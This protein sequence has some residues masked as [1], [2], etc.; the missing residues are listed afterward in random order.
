MRNL[1]RMFRREAWYQQGDVLIKPVGSV[2]QA[3]SPVAG[4]VLAEGEATGHK[5]AAV[6]ED[7]R[8]FILDG[9]L[10]MHA[11]TGTRVVHEEHHE[12]EIPPG[13]YV[14]DK[15]REYDHFAEEARPVLD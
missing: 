14:I 9:T 11:P 3:A 8:L 15:V 13:T 4:R 5:H 6:A 10:Y 2:P 1:A 12:Q 7:V